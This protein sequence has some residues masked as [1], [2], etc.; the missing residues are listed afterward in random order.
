MNA[1][2][3]VLAALS[4]K[5]PD[6]L[7]AFCGRI[8]D[9]SYWLEHFNVKSERELRALW[10]L[11][12]QK[13]SYGDA[14]RLQP[15]K[16]VWGCDDDWDAG[17]SSEKQAPLANA[18]SVA[19]VERHAWP[20]I[21][22]VEFDN[23]SRAIAQMDPARARIGSI[24]FQAVFCTLCDLFGME[25]TMVNMHV[26]GGLIEAAV[27]RIGDFLYETIDRILN[28]N[29]QNIDFFWWGDDFSTQRGMMIAPETWRRFL[30]PTYLKIFR[31]IKSH[32]VLVWFHSCG[33]FAPVIGELVDGGM[34]VWETVQA[35]LDGNEP[36]SLKEKYGKDLAFFGAINCQNTLPFGTP[37]DVRKEVR[38]RFRVLGRDGGYIVGPDHSLQKNMPWQNIEA[39]FDEA[40]KCRY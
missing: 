33:S 11:D 29:A 26:N 17:Y 35:H 39:L 8:D 19:E 3:R 20:T 27:E 28:E 9:L 1:R 4:K 2:E 23:I 24:G 38:E 5:Q 15:G 7:P 12:C 25:G 22:Q 6:R 36:A 34:D 30:K 16:T 13:M 10:G 31:L 14:F 18:E 32:G 37:E 40:M 21:D